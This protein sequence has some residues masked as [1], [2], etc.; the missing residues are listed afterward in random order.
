MRQAARP[1]F[2]PDMR[3]PG[4]GSRS[5]VPIHRV[6]RAGG[7]HAPPGGAMLRIWKIFCTFRSDSAVRGR[8]RTAPPGGQT[9]RRGGPGPH[10]HAEKDPQIHAPGPA[11]R[12]SSAVAPPRT[13]LHPGHSGAHP[14]GGRATGRPHP[15]HGALDRPHPPGLSAPPHRHRNPARGA[16][17]HAALVRTPGPRRQSGTAAAPPD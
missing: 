12:A 15:G 6:Y 16:G 2:S 10:P 7:P 1:E 4:G 9:A 13:V 5:D 8:T 11:C 3:P 14:P 17:R